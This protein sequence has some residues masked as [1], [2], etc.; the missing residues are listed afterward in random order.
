MFGF[1][2]VKG[3]SGP[4]AI[5]T[6]VCRVKP[7]LGFFDR[8]NYMLCLEA[9]NSRPY[10][11]NNHDCSNCDAIAGALVLLVEAFRI[12]D[13]GCGDAVHCDLSFNADAP[14]MPG[15]KTKIVLHSGKHQMSVQ[16]LVQN[17]I[18]GLR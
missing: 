17:I 9:Q 7:D 2:T 18:T 4:K 15:R 10:I 5:F 16:L 14:I 1:F 8:K 11:Q 3:F 12:E 13:S 6:S